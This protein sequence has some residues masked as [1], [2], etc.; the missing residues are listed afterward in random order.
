MRR[1]L[2]SDVKRLHTRKP[3][4]IEDIDKWNETNKVIRYLLV[5][6][7]AKPLP[8]ET[9]GGLRLGSDLNFACLQVNPIDEAMRASRKPYDCPH[10]LTQMHLSVIE[11]ARHEQLCIERRKAAA[12]EASQK[13][14][15]EQQKEQANDDDRHHRQP[16][17]ES[18]FC[19]QCDRHFRHFSKIDILRHRATH[20]SA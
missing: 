7:E 13:Q 17:K 14:A 12:V 11:W 1:L 2:A 5:E 20:Q 9:K 10:C 3:L 8:N 19:S 18:Y 16:G 15:K 4:S 6:E